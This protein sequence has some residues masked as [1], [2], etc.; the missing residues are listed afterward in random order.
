MDAAGYT[1]SRQTFEYNFF[2]ETAPPVLLG[3]TP[4]PFPYTY[5]DGD[6]ISTMDYSGSGSVTGVVQEAD[7]TRAVARRCAR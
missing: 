4:S 7:V 3:L 2:E 1:V 5:D 6:E